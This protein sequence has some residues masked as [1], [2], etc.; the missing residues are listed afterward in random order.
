ME[1]THN[2]AV[3]EIAELLIVRYGERAASHASLQ[4]LKARNMGLPLHTEAWKLI[5]DA[6]IQAMRTEEADYR[7]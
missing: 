7:R 6:V 5:A 4:A 3:R 2:D 1:A